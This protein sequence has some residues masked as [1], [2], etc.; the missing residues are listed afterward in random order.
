MQRR[1]ECDTAILV[2]ILHRVA[3][4]A[5]VAL[6]IMLLLLLIPIV[7]VIA[8]ACC[9]RTK[10]IRPL[11]I[12]MIIELSDIL[13]ITV[14]TLVFQRSTFVI[15]VP[16]LTV[17]LFYFRSF[18]LKL[19]YLLYIIGTLLLEVLRASGSIYIHYDLNIDVKE[20]DALVCV[21]AYLQILTLI[22]LFTHLNYN[23][24][25][26]PESD[27]NTGTQQ[28]LSHLVVFMFGTVGV[29]FVNAGALLVELTLKARNGERTVDL[30]VILL[31]TESVFAACCLA[32]QIYTFWKTKR[33]RFAIGI[34]KLRQCKKTQRD[35]PP[36]CDEHKMENL[37][38]DPQPSGS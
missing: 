19:S 31:P 12:Y 16:L 7:G 11:T 25:P 8:V 28:S 32:L 14:F 17:I 20:R 21:T 24:D 34:N 29:V 26:D 37:A 6:I 10:T 36:Q 23:S 9:K 22:T 2:D 1:F 15:L 30:R 5:K 18:L 4:E 33:K 13:R 27:S 35:S 3:T 38:P